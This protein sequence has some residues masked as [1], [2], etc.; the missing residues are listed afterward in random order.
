MAAP[1]VRERGGALDGRLHAVAG[2]GD[3][4][5]VALVPPGQQLG[6]ALLGFFESG[7]LA[8]EQLDLE[9][10]G[11]QHARQ[12]ADVGLGELQVQVGEPAPGVLVD[13][14]QEGILAALLGRLGEG[15]RGAEAGQEQ[16]GRGGRPGGRG[17]GAWAGPPTNKCGQPGL[18]PGGDTRGSRC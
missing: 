17:G 9:A 14:D 15:H 3:V 2:Q 11:L 4:H 8:G 18:S 13:A 16:R 1:P 6:R 7:V 10:A 12:V 5:Q